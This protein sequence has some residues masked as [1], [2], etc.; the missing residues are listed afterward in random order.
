MTRDEDDSTEEAP[1][2]EDRFF[3]VAIDLLCV[4]D[5][6]G[7]FKRLNP[8]WDRT[9][10]FTIAELQSK[11]FVEFVTSIADATA[12]ANALLTDPHLEVKAVGIEVVT[13]YQRDFAPGDLHVYKRWLSDNHSANWA[14]TDATCGALIGPLLVRYPTLARRMRSW[15]RD[16][17][18][19]VRRA[20]AV[21]LIPSVRRGLALDL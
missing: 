14:T 8:A 18:M 12:F 6:N 5:F 19:W 10:G 3:A 13:R 2:L 1:T 15:A 7:Y 20:A 4:L 21:G 11:P 9:L 17:N 16:R